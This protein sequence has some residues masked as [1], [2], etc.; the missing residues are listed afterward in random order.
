MCCREEKSQDEFL[1]R[2]VYYDTLLRTLK[3]LGVDPDA[4]I[5]FDSLIKE[6]GKQR[7]YGLLAGAMHLAETA[8]EEDIKN[9]KKPSTPRQDFAFKLYTTFIVTYSRVSNT[10]HGSIKFNTA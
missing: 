2:Y 1:L 3:S 8:T 10:R 9:A 7:E 5:R 4:A 6:F